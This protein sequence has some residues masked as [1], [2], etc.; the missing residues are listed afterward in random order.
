MDFLYLDIKSGEVKC[1]VEGMLLLEVKD[2]WN[3]DKRTA[4]KPFFHKAITFI[5]H[6][7]K[8]DHVFSNS[9]P[10]LRKKKVMH[11][12]LPGIDIKSLEGNMRVIRLADR[13]I[14]EQYSPN[15]WFYEGIKRDMEDLKKH[16]SSIP[17]FKIE[18]VDRN[19]VVNI[20]SNRDMIEHT[21]V[22]KQEEK[23]D[24]SQEK[25]AAMEKALKLFDL[26]EKIKQKISKE[27]KEK[28]LKTTSS[29][30]LQRGTLA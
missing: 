4:S 12:F 5:Y 15:E 7:Y 30:M 18:K 27:S 24:N 3:A 20:P 13:F 17:F 22:I 9:G 1:T 19:V 23:V 6:M 28:R 21:V 29:S 16:I 14:Q 2:L 11:D 26:E 25:L 8:K 10:V